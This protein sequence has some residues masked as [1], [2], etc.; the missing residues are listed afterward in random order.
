MIERSYAAGVS[1]ACRKHAL[2]APTEIDELL[3]A[4]ETAKDVPPDARQDVTPSP[5][6][7][8]LFQS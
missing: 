6:P 4:V 5:D 3:A 2:A 8:A 1:F 7:A